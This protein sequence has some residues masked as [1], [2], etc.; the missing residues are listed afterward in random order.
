MITLKEINNYI[1]DDI[2][3]TI[4]ETREDEIYELRSKENTEM[5]TIL[6]ENPMDYDR[7]LLIIEN[8]TPHFCNH[9]RG[10]YQSTKK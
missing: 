1:N 4:Y 10:N 2:L 6:K 8:L 3:Q 7:L 5:N 9:K